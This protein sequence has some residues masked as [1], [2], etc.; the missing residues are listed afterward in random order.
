MFATRPTGRLITALL[1]DLLAKSIE[2]ASL[3][4][5][6]GPTVQLVRLYNDLPATQI[7]VGRS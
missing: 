5:H 6:C 4:V 2:A 1:T 3:T 7:G